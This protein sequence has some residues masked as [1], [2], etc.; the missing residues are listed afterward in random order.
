[1]THEWDTD[2]VAALAIGVIACITDLRAR[3]I[4]KVLTFGAAAVGFSYQFWSQGTSGALHSAGGWLLG[5]AVFLPLFLLRGMGGGDVKLVGALGAWL[6]VRD[7]FWVALY[8]AL[9][10]G[11]M[12]VVVAL[13]HRRLQRSASSVLMLLWYWRTQGLRPL[14]ALTLEAVQGPRLAYALPILAGVVLRMWL[15]A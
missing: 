5:V 3:R 7:V 14:P 9:A 10:G 12:A 4:P 15:P 11:V 13:W 8:A 1:M 2:W 6:G